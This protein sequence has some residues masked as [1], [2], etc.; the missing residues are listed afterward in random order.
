[1]IEI[2][3][4]ADKIIDYQNDYRE[5]SGTMERSINND[6]LNYHHPNASKTCPP[7]HT[8]TQIQ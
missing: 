6:K 1:M 3:S 7:K 4:I 5:A 2:I 8:H